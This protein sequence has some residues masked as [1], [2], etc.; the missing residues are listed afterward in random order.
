MFSFFLHFPEKGSVPEIPLTRLPKRVEL[1]SCL[2]RA[3]KTRLQVHTSCCYPQPKKPSY[4]SSLPEKKKTFSH[5]QRKVRV[6][7][8]YFPETERAIAKSPWNCSREDPKPS[9][10][11][12]QETAKTHM[13]LKSKKN[14]R[15]H[16]KRDRRA[17]GRQRPVQTPALV[18]GPT[19]T[20]GL[21]ADPWGTGGGSATATR[22]RS[23]D[24]SMPSWMANRH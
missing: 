5:T 11:P 17:V 3:P 8:W 23:E 6:V 18:G 12:A 9:H 10:T 7:C 15:C 22:Q 19:Q 1:A 20:C 2:G 21:S 13:Y 4:E 24:G 16:A 14:C